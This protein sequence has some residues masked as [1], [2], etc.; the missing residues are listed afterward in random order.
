MD[1][2]A[3]SES[4]SSD[5]RI[6]SLLTFASQSPG[7]FSPPILQPPGR[8]TPSAMASELLN[9]QAGLASCLVEEEKEH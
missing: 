4:S 3:G 2:V 9:H 7:Q 6:A 5:S 1:V 8:L